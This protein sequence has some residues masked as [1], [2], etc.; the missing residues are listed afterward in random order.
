MYIGFPNGIPN[1]LITVS[2]K[3]LFSGLLI[4]DSVRDRL[5]TKTFCH[6]IPECDEIGFLRADYFND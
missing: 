4:L 5:A 3:S 6:L 2:F 1:S